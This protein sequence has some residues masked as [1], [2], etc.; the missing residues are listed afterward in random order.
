MGQPVRELAVVGEQ[1]QAL[2]V[3][4]EPADMEQP[5]GPVAEEVRYGLA[6][7]RVRHRGQ[8]LGRLVESQVDEAGL[9][10][11]ALAVDPD[12]LAV[13]VDPGAEPADRLAVD[14]DPASADELLAVP[15]A[16]DPGLGQDLLQPDAVRDIGQRIP[17]AL[18]VLLVLLVVIVVV[19]LESTVWRS[20]PR[21]PQCSLAGTAPGPA[22][23]PGWPGPAARGS[24]RWS[25]T[26]W[27]R[28]PGPSPPPRSGRAAPACAS[29]RRS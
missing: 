21:C 10:R 22:G 15:A 17:F 8:H 7:A 28:S 16:A 19:G 23:P 20:H 13:G 25:G 4:I 9:G 26:R 24:T 3:V 29:H 12:H 1:H 2:G 11:D 14:L 18:L 27:P 6:A 5:L